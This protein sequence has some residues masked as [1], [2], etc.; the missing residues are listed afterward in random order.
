ME[1]GGV[2]TELRTLCIGIVAFA[3]MGLL[4]VPYIVVGIVLGGIYVW[5]VV[6]LLLLTLSGKGGSTQIIGHHDDGLRKLKS[7]MVG[8]LVPHR[9]M[10]RSNIPSQFET[11]SLLSEEDPLKEKEQEIE[12]DHMMEVML[13]VG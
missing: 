5:Y 12:Y 7:D 1:K 2:E 11:E 6:S 13:S 8:E 10:L 4:N 9:G 3:L